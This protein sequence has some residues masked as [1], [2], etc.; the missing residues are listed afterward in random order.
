MTTAD[1]GRRLA[2]V[3]LVVLGLLLVPSIAIA[4]FTSTRSTAPLQV[5]T[6]RMETPAAVTGTYQCTYVNHQPRSE[7]FAVT[8][9]SFSDAGPAGATYDYRLSGRVERTAS[10]TARTVSLSTG[11]LSSDGAATQWTVTIRAR[12]GS[13]TGP[14][15]T[16]TIGCPASRSS[17]GSL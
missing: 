12:L 5:S 4:Q 14:A 17:S 13:W 2:V 1:H 16:R 7:S 10:T 15:Y 6:D 3:L 11:P 8:I 9:T